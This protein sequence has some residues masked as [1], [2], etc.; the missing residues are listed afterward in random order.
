MI[1]NLKRFFLS[2]LKKG[3]IGLASA[4]LL[5]AIALAVTTIGSNVTTDGNVLPGS[6][7]TSDLGAFGT[8]FRDVYSSSSIRVGNG[9]GASSTFSASGNLTL[10][11]ATGGGIFPATGNT[12]DLG[13]SSTPWRSISAST[14]IRLGRESASTTLGIASNSVSSTKGQGTCI[15]L[16]AADGTLV[17]LSVTSTPTALRPWTSLAVSTASCE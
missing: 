17:Y 10:G 1:N 9:A 15:A 13:A 11:G 12:L 5:P 2:L 8:A 3:G 7:N 6:N 14:S 16:R 4:L